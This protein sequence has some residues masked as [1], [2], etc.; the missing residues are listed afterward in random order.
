[1]LDKFSCLIKFEDKSSQ[2]NAKKLQ[3]F[4]SSDLDEEFSEEVQH[5]S[6]I[7]DKQSTLL[8]MYKM[9]KNLNLSSAFP[10]V[11]TALR[12]F[13][14]IPISN[15]TGERSFSLMKRIKSPLRSYLLQEKLSHL[16]VLCLNSDIT[17]KIDYND[18]IDSF[19]S[20]KIRK[21]P[22]INM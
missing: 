12:I 2:D 7:I 6:T 20:N 14:T 1:M 21:K 10:N 8:E 5:F 16:S 15:C 13:L 18:L 17:E 3:E 19:A 4:Y 9:L 22:L 11:E